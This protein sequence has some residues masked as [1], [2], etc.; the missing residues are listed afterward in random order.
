MKS[1]NRL[2]AILIGLLLLLAVADTV[3]VVIGR[4]PS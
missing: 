1:L 4:L 3:Y 2:D